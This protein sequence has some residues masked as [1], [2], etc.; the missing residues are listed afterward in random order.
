M[1]IA[2]LEFSRQ[3]IDGL[4]QCQVVEDAISPW[5]FPSIIVHRIVDGVDKRRLVVDF[6]V[7]NSR[8]VHDAFPM[9]DCDWVLGMLQRAKYYSKLDLKSGFWQVGLSERAKNVCV[10]LTKEANTVLCACHSG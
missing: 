4:K 6:R 1:S 2:D 5:G 3:E 8:T 7:L 9:P 10:F